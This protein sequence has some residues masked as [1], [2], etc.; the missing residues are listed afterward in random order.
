MPPDADANDGGREPASRASA[1]ERD[2]RA[3]GLPL[4]VDVDAI[5][6]DRVRRHDEV[7]AA[8]GGSRL[9]D[10]ISGRCEK[11]VPLPRSHVDGSGDDDHDA[12]A[13][14]RARRMPRS[15]YQVLTPFRST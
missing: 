8:F 9:D 1:T 13:S 7:Q 10:G 15:S 2:Q 12:L 11:G 3:F 4:F 6:F 5:A 14:G